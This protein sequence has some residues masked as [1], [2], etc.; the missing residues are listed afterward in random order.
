MAFINLATPT[1]LLG[2]HRL[3]SKAAAVR[4]SP[5]CLGA[6]N[7]GE[8]WRASLGECSKETAFSILDYFYEQ[9]GNFIDTAVNYQFGDSEAWLAEWMES[10]NC[11]DEMVIATKFTGMQIIEKEKEGGK[12][13]KVNYCGNSTKNIYTSVA[14]S[15]KTLKTDYI[16]IYYVHLW[17]ATTSIPELMHALNDLVTSRKVLYLGI[18]DTPAWIVVKANCYARQHGLRQFSIYQ[19]RWSAA[20]RAFER[21]IIPMC[22]DEGMALAPWGALGG[23]AFKTKAQRE[24]LERGEAAG[25]R[26]MAMSKMGNEEKVSDVLEKIANTKGSD[27]P[28]TSVALAYVMHKSPYVF[29][30]V[31][32][33]KVEHLKSNIE[34]LGLRLTPE[35]IKEIDSAY[36]F[37]LG[38]PHSFLSHTG[39]VMMG[40]EDHRFVNNWAILDYVEAPKPIK[41]HEGPLD[42]RFKESGLKPIR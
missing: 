9:G 8:A 7:F 35:E 29:P 14:R 5:L 26:K 19:G 38:F 40:P 34:A 24:E 16:D 3:L 39:A 25:G 11:R 22:L 33:R 6:M 37:D 30:I 20:D 27:T 2:R 28:I 10:R 4:V 32:G 18:S 21:E 1:S 17:D 31:G 36:G 41:P 42:K 15:L 13:I 23:G 12:A